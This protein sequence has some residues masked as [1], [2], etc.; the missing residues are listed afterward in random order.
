MRTFLE[1][2][3]AAM[4]RDED[5][6]VVWCHIISNGVPG[7]LA[8]LSDF[9]TEMRFSLIG[10]GYRSVEEARGSALKKANV[11]YYSTEEW[12]AKRNQHATDAKLA[13]IQFWR[14]LDDS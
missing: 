6:H 14:C 10:L 7:E 5:Y 3:L 1:G 12:M 8:I 9:T 11:T 13:G 2:Q 4:T